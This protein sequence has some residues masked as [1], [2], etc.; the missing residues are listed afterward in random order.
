MLR[1]LRRRKKLIEEMSKKMG[2][3]Y[4][5]LL[6]ETGARLDALQKLK[7][8]SDI[9]EIRAIVAEY[10]IAFMSSRS[11]KLAQEL[12]RN[13]SLLYNLAKRRKERYE[14]LKEK[15]K[16]SEDRDIEKEPMELEVAK[17]NYEK[18]LRLFRDYAISVM[19]FSFSRDDL[20][21]SRSIIVEKPVVERTLFT[22]G[23]TPGTETKYGEEWQ[24]NVKKEYLEGEEE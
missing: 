11:P 12:D 22:G 13:L 3:D 1:W 16:N 15:L 10:G 8:S 4:I 7:S 18:A 17:R 6:G 9:D 5:S 24:E 23:F 19:S 21:V 20:D 2:I 14:E